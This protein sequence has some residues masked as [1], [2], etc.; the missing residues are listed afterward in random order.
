MAENPAYDSSLSTENEELNTA[1][2]PFEIPGLFTEVSGVIL[3][4]NSPFQEGNQLSSSEALS[5]ESVDTSVSEQINPTEENEPR[6]ID[7]GDYI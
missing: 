3:D 7:V 2:A 6:S 4:I 1:N 5:V